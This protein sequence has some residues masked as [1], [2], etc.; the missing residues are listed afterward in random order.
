M[1]ALTLAADAASAP[2]WVARW[3]GIAGLAVS[4]LT[5]VVTVMLWR[6]DGYRLAV[7]TSQ[8]STSSSTSRDRYF[9][10][11]CL[12]EVINIGRMDCVVT[13]IRLRYRRHGRWFW[14]SRPAG[15]SYEPDSGDSETS[16]TSRTLTPTE[17][18]DLRFSFPQDFFYTPTQ[19]RVEV[20]TG[21]RRFAS[22]WRPALVPGGGPRPMPPTR[23]PRQP[24]G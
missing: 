19:Y 16:P 24:R 23:R 1:S 11:Y 18:I 3:L 21:R 20:V 5:V 15:H 14:H 10:S 8:R 7:V 4:I 9:Q 17:K 2:D 12:A 13:Q 6:R 22:R